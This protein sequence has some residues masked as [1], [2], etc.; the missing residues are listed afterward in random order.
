MWSD[1][2]ANAI[3][4]DPRIRQKYPYSFSPP[5]AQ[6]PGF[7]SARVPISTQEDFIRG[8]VDGGSDTHTRRAARRPDPVQHGAA[9]AQPRPH[10][11]DLLRGHRRHDAAV[12]AGNIS[13]TAIDKASDG[14]GVRY[15]HGGTTGQLILSRRPLQDVSVVPFD[16]FLRHRAAVYATVGG[17]KIGFADWPRNVLSDF[18]PVF[19]PYQSGALQ[20]DFAADAIAKGVDVLVGTVNTAPAYQPEAYTLLTGNGYTSKVTRPTYCPTSTHSAFGPCQV[21]QQ[22]LVQYPVDSSFD[23]VLVRST[24]S[25]QA[26]T[27]FGAAVPASTHVGLS[28]LCRPPFPATGVLDTFDRS[29]GKVGSAWDGGAGTAF[30]RIAA[31]RLVV[32]IGG[33]LVWKP[34]TFGAA[35]EAFVILSAIAPNGPAQGVLL[36]VQAG[37]VPDAGAISATYDARAKAVRVSA[38]RVGARAWTVY[39]AVPVTFAAGDVLGA[40]ARPD[41]SVELYRNGALLGSVPL[42]AA[43]AAYFAAKGGRIG[44]WTVAAPIA[45]LDS[46]GGGTVG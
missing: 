33:P 2:A 26:A 21:R 32:Q 17:V 36:K 34:A 45:A 7:C 18:D 37:S 28:V 27:P 13:L 35:Q 14:T 30:Y 23:D 11:I 39:P 44:I 24:V 6:E 1:A 38:L 43:D 42:S 40:R 10:R 3:V 4:N 9:R 41:G 20:R 16:T 25:C 8:L 12:P 31:N 5:P 19:A 22:D 46:F 15:S 29:D